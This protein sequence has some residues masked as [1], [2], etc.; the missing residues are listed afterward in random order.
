[1]NKVIISDDVKYIGVDDTTLDLFESQYVVPHGVS[2]NSYLILDDKIAVMDTVDARKTKE[3]FAN[4]EHELKDRTPDYLV[5]SHLEPDHSANIQLFVEKYPQVKLVLSAKAKAMLLQFFDIEDIDQR[6]LVVKE[7][8]VLDLGK[9]HLKFIMAPMVH[10][11]EVMVEYE[12]EEKILFSADGFGKFGALLYEEDWACE[13]RRYYFNIV[14]KYG[15]PVQTLL[16]KA[17]ALDIQM[18][19]PLHGPILKDNLSYYIDKYQIWSRYESEDEG[20]FVACASIHGNTKDVALKVVEMLKAKGIKVAFADLTRDDMAE[21]IEDAFRYS[22][23]ILAAA[24]YDGGIFSPMEDFL[25][26]LQHKG[27]QNKTVGL[28]ENGSWAPLANKV[29]KDL[30]ESMKNINICQ[31]TVT[32]K[33]TYK[34]ENLEAINQLLDEINE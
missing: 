25:H 18:I 16:K 12:T 17:S 2:Y 4:L 19:C 21:A 20:V 10:W 32:I 24:T 5:V 3:W 34:N 26:R 28:I 8:Q 31:N 11:P 13:A 1:M 33:S 30:L 7:G 22:K 27:Y 9:H 15:G 23:M 14:G 6:C 29:M